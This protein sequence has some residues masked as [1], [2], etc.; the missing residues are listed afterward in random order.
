MMPRES[1]LNAREIP[2]AIAKRS[3][4]GYMPLMTAGSM[5]STM[6]NLAMAAAIVADSRIFG[7]FLK[8]TIKITATRETSTA[9]IGFIE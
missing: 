5:E 4:A 7:R 1:T 3:I 2:G 8:S 6:P 9:A